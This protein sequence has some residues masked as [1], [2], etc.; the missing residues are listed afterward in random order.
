MES[1]KLNYG[2][3]RESHLDE[4]IRLAF[5]QAD[6][7]EAQRIIAGCD[8]PHEM[9]GSVDPDTAYARFLEKM[10]AED[11][12]EKKIARAQRR[13]KWAPRLIEIAACLVLLT[14]IAT[15]IAIANVEV[16]R[17]KVM[18]MLISIQDEY[19]EISMIENEDAAF[20]VPSG[21]TG[22]YYPTYIPE[23]YELTNVD[24]FAEVLTFENSY[25]D[26]LYF[27]ECTIDK[28][29][30]LDSERAI[31]RHEKIHGVDVL[32]I[33]NDGI[34]M[35]VWQM[36]NRYIVVKSSMDRGELIKIVG[37]VKKIIK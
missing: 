30:N 37:G 22:E 10:K 14:G 36:E 9:D 8:A 34:S 35:L 18:E 7:L 23:G 24:Q 19:T 25:S 4:M 13:R 26:L 29:A 21:W 5:K 2:D 20:Y 33:E 27:C 32:V 17:V 1:N 28:I 11:R 6:A 31:A 15:P 3:I 12:R 16:I